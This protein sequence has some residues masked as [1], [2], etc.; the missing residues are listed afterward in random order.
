MAAFTKPKL[1]FS[2]FSCCLCYRPTVLEVNFP[3]SPQCQAWWIGREGKVYGIKKCGFL[4]LTAE[5]DD[6]RCGKQRKRKKMAREEFRKILK[7]WKTGGPSAPII[8]FRQECHFFNSKIH[9][10]NNYKRSTIAPKSFW[11]KMSILGVNTS[12][13]TLFFWKI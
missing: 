5:D 3:L 1:F 2:F 4:P 10:I 13:P 8:F 12:Y 7:K 9:D 6:K 11:A